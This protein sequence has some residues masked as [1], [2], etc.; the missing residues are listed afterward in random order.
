MNDNSFI[1]NNLSININ[2]KLD[3]ILL[4]KY[5]LSKK[6]IYKTTTLVLPYQYINIKITSFKQYSI[7]M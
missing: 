2:I 5:L 7:T 4:S 1:F 3:I 6:W